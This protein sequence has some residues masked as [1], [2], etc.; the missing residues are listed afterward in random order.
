MKSKQYILKFEEV[1][2]KDVGM[3]AG[4]MRRSAK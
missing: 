2:I 4:K 1:G 3:V